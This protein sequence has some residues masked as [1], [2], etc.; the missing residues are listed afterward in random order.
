MMMPRQCV[1]PTRAIIGDLPWC[2]W[3]RL[4]KIFFMISGVSS[5]KLHY[6]SEVSFIHSFFSFSSFFIGICVWQRVWSTLAIVGDI[7]WCW[8]IYPI[9]IFSM[10]QGCYHQNV[11]FQGIILSF[12]LFFF[13]S[14]LYSPWNLYQLILTISLKYRYS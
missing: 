9:E 7:P 4:I 3:T 6:I 2:F 8:W 11:D 1:W 10:I 14:L 13:F 12:F 5:S